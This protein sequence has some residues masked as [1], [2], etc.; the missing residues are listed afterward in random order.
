MFRAY[1]SLTGEVGNKKTFIESLE[2][3]I[4]SL[5]KELNDEGEIAVLRSKVQ[6]LE[7]RVNS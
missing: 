5:K 4:S 7:D 3:T 1:E 6:N 2:E